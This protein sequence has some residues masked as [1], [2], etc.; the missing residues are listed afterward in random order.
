MQNGLFPGAGCCEHDQPGGWTSV[1]WLGSSLGNLEGDA[2]WRGC[3]FEDSYIY[4]R[5]SRRVA[6]QAEFE[7]QLPDILFAEIG[8][9]PVKIAIKLLAADTNRPLFL[10]QAYPNASFSLS[11]HCRTDLVMVSL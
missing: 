1:R 2:L 9:C 4:G 5:I 10:P 3:R 8:T 7:I 11:V 6:A